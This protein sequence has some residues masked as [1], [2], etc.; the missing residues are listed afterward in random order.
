M[1]P[2]SIQQPLTT[3]MRE[4]EYR[5]CDISEGSGWFRERIDVY[6]WPSRRFE[7]TFKRS[8]G[9]NAPKVEP[10]SLGEWL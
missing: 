6:C 7:L 3:R 4:S 5:V 9:E 8:L 2:L 10:G 1:Q